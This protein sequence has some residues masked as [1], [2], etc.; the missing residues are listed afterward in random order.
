MGGGAA[1]RDFAHNKEKSWDGT[2]EKLDKFPLNLHM[3]TCMTLCADGG[4]IID[5]RC[6]LNGFI[7]PT[8]VGIAAASATVQHLKGAVRVVPLSGM[9][10]LR[11]IEVR[12]RIVEQVGR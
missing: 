1:K 8:V 4:R 7:E 12:V 11:W 3:S 9:A 5:W 2:D 10:G 6:Y